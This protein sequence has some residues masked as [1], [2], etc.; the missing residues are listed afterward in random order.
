MKRAVTIAGL[1]VILCLVSAIAQAAVPFKHWVIDLDVKQNQ[2]EIIVTVTDGDCK[3]GKGDKKGCIRFAT[4]HI[5][6]ITFATDKKAQTCSDGYKK[7]VITKIELTDKGLVYTDGKVSEK[8]V[9]E[10]NPSL[11]DWLEDAFPQLV[12][13]T[14]VLYEASA[15]LDGVTQVTSLNLNNND[16]TLGVKDIWYRVSVAKCGTNPVEFMVTDPRFENDGSEPD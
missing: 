5:G 8:G 11:P 15:E 6:L 7:W 1:F 16:T 12:K 14:G 2:G 3:K 10:D 9:F 13:S 4:N